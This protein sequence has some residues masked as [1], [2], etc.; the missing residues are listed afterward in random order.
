MFSHAGNRI[1]VFD[2]NGAIYDVQQGEPVGSLAG[3]SQQ[4]QAVRFV[5]ENQKLV[6]TDS[7][8]EHRRQRRACLRFTVENKS[9]YRSLSRMIKYY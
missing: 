1:A 7:Q 3:N 9:A 8:T 4:I 2:K 6:V 5:N